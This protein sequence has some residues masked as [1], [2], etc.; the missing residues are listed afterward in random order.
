M[1]YFQKKYKYNALESKVKELL[2]EGVPFAYD[3]DGNF[4]MP[5]VKMY[6]KQK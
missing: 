5:D 2:L 4:I 3:D 6:K 1:C